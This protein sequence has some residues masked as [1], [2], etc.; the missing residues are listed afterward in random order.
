MDKS[1]AGYVEGAVSII[2]NLGLFGIKLWAGIAS[3]SIALV[4]DAWH[5]LSDSL[6]SIFVIAGARLS[7]K[8]P[9]KAHPFGHGR[10]EQIATIFIGVLLILV[11]YDFIKD[12]IVQFRDKESANFGTLALIV[13]IVSILTKEG[14]AQYAFYLAKKTNNLTVKADGWHHRTD[15]LSSIVVLVGI[16]FKNQF[17]W[18]DS[19]LGIIISLLLFYTAYEIINSSI[20]KLLGE[21][22]SDELIK[23]VEAIIKTTCSEDVQPHHYHLH[24]Y[25]AHQELTFHIKVENSMEI[26]H[27]HHIATEI[28]KEIY[29]QLNI[30]TTVHIEPRDFEHE[31][32]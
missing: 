7:S 32:D 21:K 30:M 9:D 1:K 22:P 10:W 29:R 16:L 14:L 18:I 27:A 12:S 15:A 4:A 23:E 17:W 25:V 26:V 19:A 8:K 20:D 3:A 28:E 24:N 5:T 6:S 13:T 31:F 11:G 2:V